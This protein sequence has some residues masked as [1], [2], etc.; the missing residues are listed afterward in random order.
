MLENGQVIEFDRKK[1]F[2]YLRPL[3]SGGTG[4]TYLFKDETTDMLFA[5]KKYSPKGDNDIKEN[6]I[7]FVDEMKILF[8][9][10]H[11]NIVRIYNYYLYPEIDLGYLQLEY[12]DGIAID[13]YISEPWIKSWDDIFT[14]TVYAFRYLEEKGILHRDIRPSNIMIDKDNN[15]KII[16][17]GFGKKIDIDDPSPNSVI[18]NWPV[19]QLP[20]EMLQKEEYSYKTEVFFIGKLF[21]NLV[22]D[23]DIEE[24]GYKDIITK[25]TQ[26]EP[27]NRYASFDEVFNAINEKNLIEIDFDKTQR[28]IYI[29][30]AKEISKHINCFKSERILKNDIPTIINE[31]LDLIR[32][33]ALE[34]YI[35][36]IEI[37]LNIFISSSY[38]IEKSNDIKFETV[39]NFYNF[40]INLPQNKQSVVIDNLHSRLSTIYITFELDDEELPF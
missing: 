19:S 12:I 6:Y 17:F 34:Y 30:F 31:L 11:P 38:T 26:V 3:G 2:T 36:N 21:S 4:D 5:I 27:K 16:D 25:M 28:K 22:I 10:S 33:N 18:L 15:V 23:E 40:F 9:I 8:N 20:K 35:Q 14:E 1:Y 13:K 24:F 39:F 7:R 29:E 32:R 37:L